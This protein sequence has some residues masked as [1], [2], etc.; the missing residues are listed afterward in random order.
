MVI[1][2]VLFSL[3]LWKFF[4]PYKLD[5]MGMRNIIRVFVF[6]SLLCCTFY[7]H[8]KI[9]NKSASSSKGA[10]LT[11]YKCKHFETFCLEMLLNNFEIIGDLDE[12]K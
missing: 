7:V 3:N 8:F 5:G 6:H 12:V 9:L 4:L 2:K 11:A 10:L 1:K